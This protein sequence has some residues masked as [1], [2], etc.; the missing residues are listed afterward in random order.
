MATKESTGV[1]VAE[2]PFAI[3]LI[4]QHGNRIESL[5]P[6]GVTL[7]RVAATLRL[8]IM[9]NPKIAECTA[10]SLIMTLG[11]IFRWGLEVGETAYIVPFYDSTKKVTEATAIMGY[12]GMVELMVASGSVRAVQAKAVYANDLFEYEQGLD[13]K[14]RHIPDT[15]LKTR[16]AIQ[17]AYCILRLG[18]GAGDVF[19][20]VGI[21]EIEEI[22]AKSKQWSP[23]KI[24]PVCPGWYAA[25]TAVRRTSKLV[26]KNP[27]LA[28]A[29]AAL[30]EDLGLLPEN[31]VA[32]IAAPSG[33][34]SRTLPDEHRGPRPL[35]TSGMNGY[36]EAPVPPAQFSDDP[37]ASA[38][39]IEW[40][41]DRDLEDGA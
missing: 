11:R 7:E 3:A 18:R 26:P 37:G 36:D 33:T 15:H 5:L 23:Q 8:E 41:D 27:R 19:D 13:A 20:Y 21:D 32:S 16:G 14:L 28:R 1:A 22:R 17:G 29:M 10:P 39:D 24:G 25:K 38:E 6:P 40:Q 31:Q 9:K 2:K 4:E 30:D 35:A 12:T 34:A